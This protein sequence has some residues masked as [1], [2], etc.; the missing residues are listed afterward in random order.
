MIILY[1]FIAIL[2][3]VSIGIIIGIHAK[4][5]GE[6]H[7]YSIIFLIPLIGF[8]MINSKF[9][10]IFPFASIFHS[11]Y[12]LY[13]LVLPSITVLGLF[14]LMIFDVKRL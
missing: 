5:L 12:T 10:Y 11:N 9:S 13:T 4:N 1:S 2:I 7:L 8:T 6:I 14:F 3:V